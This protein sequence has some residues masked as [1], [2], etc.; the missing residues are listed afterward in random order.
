MGSF[1]S[2]RDR[3]P[4]VKVYRHLTR[5]G[6]MWVLDEQAGGAAVHLEYEEPVVGLMG[7][8][9]AGESPRLMMVWPGT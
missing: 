2:S 7:Q 8:E 1:N 4:G 6:I 3:N 9:P 5:L